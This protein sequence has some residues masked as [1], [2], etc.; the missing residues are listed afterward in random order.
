MKVS[1]GAR[2]GPDKNIAEASAVKPCAASAILLYAFCKESGLATHRAP[3][4]TPPLPAS[5]RV[6]FVGRTTRDRKSCGIARQRDGH[7]HAM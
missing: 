3:F 6:P 2:P 4:Q 1:C 7:P 5:R